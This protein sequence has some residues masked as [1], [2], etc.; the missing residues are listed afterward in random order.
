M[1]KILLLNLITLTL[2]FGCGSKKEI[3]GNN[4]KAMYDNVVEELAAEEG[5]FPWIFSAT[6]YDTINDTLKEI[7]IR[8]TYS[9]YA[10]LAELRTLNRPNGPLRFW[11]PAARRSLEP[12]LP[13]AGALAA[14]RP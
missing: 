10:T 11:Q 3:Q 13:R 12:R 7:Q 14:A 9:P 5:G 4:A 8:Y 1:S 2:I 6:D